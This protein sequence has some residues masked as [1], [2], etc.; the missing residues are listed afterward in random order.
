MPCPSQ[1][2]GF[3]VPNYVSLNKNII[4]IF[5]PVEPCAVHG[6]ERMSAIE[7]EMDTVKSLKDRDD[8]RGVF[9]KKASVVTSFIESSHKSF[10]PL[11]V[12]LARL[13]CEPL[14]HCCF[15]FIVAIKTLTTEELLESLMLAGNELQSL[16]RA[17]V[18]EDE[19]EEV[20]WDG[21][22]SIVSWRER[23]FRLWWEERTRASTGWSSPHYANHVRALLDDTFPDRWI[24][25]GGPTP[26]PSRSPDMTPLDFFLWG[27]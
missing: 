27:L 1:T 17:I 26:W 2:S 7:L 4:D 19:Y 14:P 11:I 8:L 6:F 5:Y 18:K 12:E 23:V 20:R 13:R 22:V 15:H 21:I 3:N 25:R 16:G 24:G 10:Y 9:L